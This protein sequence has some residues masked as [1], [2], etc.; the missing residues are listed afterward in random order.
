VLTSGL[1]L[2]SYAPTHPHAYVHA[3][4]EI[5]SEL[6]FHHLTLDRSGTMVKYCPQVNEDP[7]PAFNLPIL[8]SIFD[9]FP[10]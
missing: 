1:L 8:V 2:C 4:K 9:Y 5:Q 7:D 10:N 3:H 6:E